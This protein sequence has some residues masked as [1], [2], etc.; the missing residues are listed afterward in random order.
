MLDAENSDKKHVAHAQNGTQQLAVADCITFN[1]F[2]SYNRV[3]VEREALLSCSI[4]L[5]TLLTTGCVW[6][7]FPS[8]R[9]WLTDVQK[10][11]KLQEKVYVALQRCLQ[12]D[13]ASEEKLTR[14]SACC[15]ALHVQWKT[16]SQLFV[17]HSLAGSSSP[18]GLQTPSYEVHLQPSH[19]QTGVFPPG[20]P[21]DGVHLSSS[22]QGGFWQR[23]H[24][25]R[26][27]GGLATFSQRV[28]F[29]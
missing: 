10:V 24:L 7:L 8:D 23:S 1:G 25:P 19:R 17:T 16:H 22:V 2:L 20:S 4:S 9:P 12:K 13:G 28:W 29:K 21:W 5:T 6:L 26:F 18:D 27:H 3:R 11:Q 14:V 15:T